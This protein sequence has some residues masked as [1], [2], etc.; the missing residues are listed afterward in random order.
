VSVAQRGFLKF[1]FWFSGL[2]YWWNLAHW[3][4]R[5]RNPIFDH[6]KPF[7]T[8]KR[9]H[10]TI[11]SHFQTTKCPQFVI[12]DCDRV[13]LNDSNW[14]KPNPNLE[15]ENQNSQKSKLTRFSTHLIYP[16]I[17]CTCRIL[18]NPSPKVEWTTWSKT[19]W[20]IFIIFGNF[21]KNY[22]TKISFWWTSMVFPGLSTG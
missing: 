20:K 14:F 13:I 9:A 15:S 7:L 2:V 17:W 10:L 19:G 12:F 4:H 11:L 22:Q 16:F 18:V 6:E 5:R 3:N 1:E 8:I 21:L